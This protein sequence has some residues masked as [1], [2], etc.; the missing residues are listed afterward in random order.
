MGGRE[1]APLAA[2]ALARLAEEDGNA[3]VRQAAKV[4][5]DDI[6]RPMR[7]VA[8][9]VGARSGNGKLDID[10]TSLGGDHLTTISIGP[11]EAAAQLKAELAKRLQEPAKHLRLVTPVATVLED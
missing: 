7:V 8:L 1:A 10:C 4:A 2:E 3:D 6:Q 9:H 11:D 5:R